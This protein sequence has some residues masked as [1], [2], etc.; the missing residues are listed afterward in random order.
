MVAL[1]W[2]LVAQ[3]LQQLLQSI[4]ELFDHSVA[5]RV[6]SRYLQL[7]DGQQTGQCTL[8]SSQNP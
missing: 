7:P 5:S 6:I 3:S 1:V 4:I 2:L 8:P